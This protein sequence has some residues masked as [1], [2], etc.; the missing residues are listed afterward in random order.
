MNIAIAIHKPVS[1]VILSEAKNPATSGSSRGFI[2]YQCSAPCKPNQLRQP[3]EGAGCLKAWALMFRISLQ[4]FAQHH[5]AIS[6]IKSIHA[7]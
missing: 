5:N 3:V 2:A 1:N 4:R 7:S 6:W